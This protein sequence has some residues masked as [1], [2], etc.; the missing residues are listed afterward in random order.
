[1]KS[2]RFYPR[3]EPYEVAELLRDLA[4]TLEGAGWEQRGG[5]LIRNHQGEPV[6]RTDWIP[7]SPWWA[8]RPHSFSERQVAGI[9]LKHLRMQRLTRREAHCLND[10]LEVAGIMPRAQV[11]SAPNIEVNHDE[12]T[13]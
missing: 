2:R 6:G 3:A 1:V 11:E 13:F 10:M 5:H 7:K 8:E 4:Q 12:A 9:L